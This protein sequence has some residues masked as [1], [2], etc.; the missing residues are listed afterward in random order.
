[1]SE[2]QIGLL[3]IGVLVVIG[4]F[5]YNKWQERKYRIETDLN[6]KSGH[7]DVLLRET[8]PAGAGERPPKAAADPVAASGERIEPVMQ[9]RKVP[10][11]GAP[12]E[13]SLNESLDF[14]VAVESSE[15]IEG[16]ALIQAASGAL[17]GFAKPVR[18]EGYNGREARWEPLADRE[19]YAM[20]RAGLQLSDRRGP[21]SG[22]ELANF[23]AAVQE[24][25]Q[26]AGV[27]AMVPDRADAV[28]RAQELDRFCRE[29]DILVAIGVMGA[30][31]VQLPGT[32]IRGLAE[33]AGF[34]LDEDGRFRR[35][36][37]KGRVVYELANLD[38]A[39]F[40]AD[41][42]RSLNFA[43][44]SL[45]LDVPRAPG[46]IRTFEQFRELIRHFAQGLDGQLVDDNRK[47]LSPAAL[48]QI[49]GQIEAVH[50]AMEA[51]GF[52]AGTPE[53]L[54]LFS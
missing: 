35:R 18:L 10:A 16:G 36:D 45:E 34:L 27:L 51:R 12:R 23:G 29:V 6:L 17:R 54:R 50:R 44:I 53:A 19:R 48:D 22:E 26:A 25:A 43:G 8:E 40:R 52:A 4:V 41:S 15:E 42:M 31:G 9:V 3:A 14:I 28:R 21:V 32:R 24:A 2:L 38:A 13:P 30:Q 7:D 20:L 46:G 1:M 11:D 47:P 33:A 49:R 37:D 5:G 39:P